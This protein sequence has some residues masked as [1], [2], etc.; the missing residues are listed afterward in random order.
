MAF[1]G[2]SRGLE[3]KA[4]QFCTEQIDLFQESFL[5]SENHFTMV[6][7]ARPLECQINLRKV[8]SRL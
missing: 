7:V 8:T 4:S 3:P 1:T 2:Y 5:A 6:K